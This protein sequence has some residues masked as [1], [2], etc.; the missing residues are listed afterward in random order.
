MPFEIDNHGNLQKQVRNAASL[1]LDKAL[2]SLHPDETA[3]SRDESVH[4]ARKRLKE[5][6]ALLRLVREGLG[7]KRFDK[8][9]KTLRDAARPLSE[10]RDSAAL[11]ESLQSLEEHYSGTASPDTFKSVRGDLQR[12]RSAIRE[13]ILIENKA[14]ER[15]EAF[16][17]KVRGR[18]GRWDLEGGSWQILKAGLHRAYERGHKAMVNASGNATD[19]NLHEWRKRAKD[20]RYQ[21]ELLEP[22]KPQVLKATATDAETLTDLLGD[23]HDLAVLRGLLDEELKDTVTHEAAETLKGLIDSRRADLQHSAMALGEKLFAET[24]GRFVDRI[25]AYWKTAAVSRPA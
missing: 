3:A 5:V 9:N 8:E 24:P 15:A 13:R 21:L 17:K 23:D 6:R 19:E 20:L 2:Q 10:L 18:A 25:K 7:P 22:L 16:V 4:N 14:L 1:Q 12:R 11:L